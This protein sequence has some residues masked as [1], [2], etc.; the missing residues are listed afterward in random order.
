MRY[1]ESKQRKKKD[2]RTATTKVRND[3]LGFVLRKA[4]CCEATERRFSGLQHRLS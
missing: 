1:C 3:D 2:N 4:R